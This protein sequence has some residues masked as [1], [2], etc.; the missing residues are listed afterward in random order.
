[1]SKWL[2][3]TM[4]LSLPVLAH[5]G[6]PRDNH[7]G[8]QARD[9]QELRQDARETR[10]DHYDLRQVESLLSRYDSARGRSARRDLLQVEEDVRRYVSSELNESHRELAQDKQEARSSA[11]EV[12]YDGNRRDDRKDHR[13]DVRDARQES[14]ALRQTRSIAQELNNLYGRMDSGSLTRKRMLI[15]D[16]VQ[17]ARAETAQNRQ[18]TR[19]DRREAREDSRWH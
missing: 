17:L 14:R 15:A 7:H 2:L 10:D 6:G 5:A 11:R 16:L 1:M 8:E 19:E 18:E 9:R 3:A 13:D 4:A 12:R